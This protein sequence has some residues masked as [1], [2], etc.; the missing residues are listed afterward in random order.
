MQWRSS[1]SVETELL[2]RPHEILELRISLLQTGGGQ[3]TTAY[4][5]AGSLSFLPFVI[6]LVT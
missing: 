3:V 6:S 1:F 4:P 5:V 2:F